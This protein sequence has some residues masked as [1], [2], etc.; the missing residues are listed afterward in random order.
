MGMPCKLW[1]ALFR[2]GRPED[3][4]AHRL[5]HRMSA[6]DPLRELNQFTPML[7]N[8]RFQLGPDR[9][10][11]EIHERDRGVLAFMSESERVLD[12][13]R[14]IQVPIIRAVAGH[15][16]LHF[17][18]PG[19][20]NP[21][22]GDLSSVSLGKLRH[23]PRHTFSA[24]GLD[25]DQARWSR[26]HHVEVRRLRAKQA[27]GERLLEAGQSSIPVP[28]N[29]ERRSRPPEWRKTVDRER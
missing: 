26:C 7:Q 29:P 5:E 15:Q 19:A 4:I 28:A 11:I 23:F 3:R 2:P 13:L 22:I 21:S 8:W 24:F 6:S 14:G 16:P 20:E 9:L 10:K 27:V 25:R 1:I 18:E 17:C 12:E